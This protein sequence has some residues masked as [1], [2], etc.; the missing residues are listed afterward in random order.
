MVEE[1]G[2][3]VGVVLWCV[4][5]VVGTGFG[6]VV[7]AEGCEGTGEGWLTVYTVLIIVFNGYVAG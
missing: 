3:V 7:A 1:C 5:V 2:P 6:V 4:V